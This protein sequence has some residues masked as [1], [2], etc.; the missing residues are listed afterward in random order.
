MKNISNQTLRHL[1]IE[2]YRA[3]LEAVT[4]IEKAFHHKVGMV[5]I[6]PDKRNETDIFSVVFNFDTWESGKE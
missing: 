3:I 6:N 5:F 2:E 4:T 1:E